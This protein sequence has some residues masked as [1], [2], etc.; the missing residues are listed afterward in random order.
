[1]SR[2]TLLPLLG[3]ALVLGVAVG[4]AHGAQGE[5]GT[6]PANVERVV[7]GDT[8]RLGSGER[9]RL[10]QIDAPEA[11]EECFAT[12]A[13]AE[14]MRL[15][16]RGRRITL[17][18]DPVSDVRDRYGRLLR[19]VHFRGTNVNVELV[20]R[21]AATPYFYDGQRGKY[22]RRLL[23]AMTEAR[24]ARRGMWGR[25]LVVWR[26]ESPVTTRPR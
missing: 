8:L 23:A 4:C 17:E 26:P 13:T 11:G 22:A 24:R 7:D 3:I 18:T 25:C 6:T 14:L 5:A 15:V 1:M 19:Y 10:L 12:R 21:G 2:K 20:R 9:V 16:P